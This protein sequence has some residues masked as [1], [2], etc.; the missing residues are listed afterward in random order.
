MNKLYDYILRTTDN[1]FHGSVSYKIFF[2]DGNIVDFKIFRS[3][4]I[5]LNKDGENNEHK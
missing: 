5:L 4:H 2:V 1:I 3:S